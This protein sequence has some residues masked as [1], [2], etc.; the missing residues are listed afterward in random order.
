MQRSAF[1]RSRRELSNELIPTSIY[2]QHLPSIQPRTSLVKFARSPC[3]DPPGLR[4]ADFHIGELQ[5]YGAHGQSSFYVAV[6]NIL[7]GPL[8][9]LHSR[10]ALNSTFSKMYLNSCFRASRLID[11]LQGFISGPLPI[12]SAQVLDKKA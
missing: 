10:R 4:T 9:L 2:L 1:C 6:L 5:K 12:S 7:R 8:V 3:T 11:F